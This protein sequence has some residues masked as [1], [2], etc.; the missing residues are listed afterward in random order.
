MEGGR[1][2][3]GLLLVFSALFTGVDASSLQPGAQVLQKLKSTM[4]NGVD[5]VPNASTRGRDEPRAHGAG[6][7]PRLDANVQVGNTR[8]TCLP[9][10]MRA[11][12]FG[13]SGRGKCC[14]WARSPFHRDD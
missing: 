11:A 13:R 5:C 1:G 6:D 8:H 4:K 7:S 10:H 14:E 2:V 9:L 3:G 12:S